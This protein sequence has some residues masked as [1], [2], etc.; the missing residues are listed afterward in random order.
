MGP[1][2]PSHNNFYILDAVDYV[3]KWVKAIATPTNDSMV[4]LKFLRKNIFT[5]FGTPRAI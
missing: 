1:F 3:S 2:P 5:R 4:V